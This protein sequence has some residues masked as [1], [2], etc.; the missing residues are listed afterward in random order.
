MFFV[1]SAQFEFLFE[2]EAQRRAKLVKKAEN[3]LGTVSNPSAGK[4]GMD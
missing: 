3:E 1:R 4:P 2:T